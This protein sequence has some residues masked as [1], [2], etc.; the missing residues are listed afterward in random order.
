M[1]FNRSPAILVVDDDPDMRMLVEMAVSSGES[2]VLSCGDGDT[3]LEL[4]LTHRADIV[5]LDVVLPGSL[6]GLAVCRRLKVELPGCFVIM[7]SGRSLDRDLADAERAGA[8]AYF[9]KPVSLLELGALIETILPKP[10]EPPRFTKSAR[11][12]LRHYVG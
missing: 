1:K 6:D 7:L 8:D 9:V 4:A 10:G 11:L 3:A 2:E 12:R 5:V